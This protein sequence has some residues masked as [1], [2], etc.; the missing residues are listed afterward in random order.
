VTWFGSPDLRGLGRANALLVL[1][2]GEGQYRAGQ[3]LSV[4]PLEEG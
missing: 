3:V 2:A 1:P 4:I